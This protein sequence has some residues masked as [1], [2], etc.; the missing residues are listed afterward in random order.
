MDILKERVF[1]VRSTVLLRRRQR[2]SFRET[3]EP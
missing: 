3:R 2:A 1:M